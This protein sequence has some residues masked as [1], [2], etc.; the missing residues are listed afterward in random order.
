MNKDIIRI[1]GKTIVESTTGKKVEVVDSEN[2][3]ESLAIENKIEYL[4]DELT[5]AYKKYNELSDFINIRTDIRKALN[6]LQAL[7]TFIVAMAAGLAG[8]FAYST[9]IAFTAGILIGGTVTFATTEALLKLTIDRYLKKAKKEYKVFGTTIDFLERD[10]SN[11]R[12]KLKNVG[13][14]QYKEYKDTTLKVEAVPKDDY[15]H[16]VETYSN[17]DELLNN[18]QKTESKSKVK[19]RPYNVYHLVEKK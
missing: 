5:K 11:E 10:L 4:N 16:M 15:D 9:G 1:N 12:E 3:K 7:G 14:V 13:E 6:V 17:L 2:L 19:S 18:N 8:G